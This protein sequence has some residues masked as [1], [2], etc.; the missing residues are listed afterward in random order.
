M[1]F[2]AILQGL[3]GSS[4]DDIEKIIQQIMALV[5]EDEGGGGERQRRPETDRRGFWEIF[6][7]VAKVYRKTQPQ[8]MGI[9]QKL[10]GGGGPIRV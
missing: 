2:E 9:L 8:F 6:P 7:E 10:T 3:G 4:G 5:P 1:G